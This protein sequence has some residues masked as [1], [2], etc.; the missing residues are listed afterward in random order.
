M[1]DSRPAQQDCIWF[2]M[3]GVTPS[4]LPS[5]GG[6]GYAAP[7]KA[8]AFVFIT[9]ILMPFAT[10]PILL[11][12]FLRDYFHRMPSPVHEEK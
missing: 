1:D 7:A 9:F 12:R 4:S 2:S 8:G 10:I 3:S 5:L 11:A 6:L